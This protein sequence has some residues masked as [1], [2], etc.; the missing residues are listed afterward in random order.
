MKE[1]NNTH[2]PMN[3]VYL[4]GRISHLYGNERF[5]SLT[6]PYNEIVTRRVRENGQSRF[7][8]SVE[9]YFPEALFNASTKTKGIIQSFREGDHVLIKGYLGAYSYQTGGGF[10]E[11][12]AIYIDE[13]EHDATRME[14]MLGLGGFNGRYADAANEI[15]LEAKIAGIS[16]RREDIYEI[17]LETRKDG[18]TYAVTGMY[19]RAPQGLDQRIHLGDTV[20]VIGAMESARSEYRG[21]VY[22]TQTFVIQELVT[23]KEFVDRYNAAAETAQTGAADNAETARAAAEVEE[24]AAG[25]EPVE[26]PELDEPEELAGAAEAHAEE[27]EEPEAGT[28]PADN[29]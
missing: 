24:P 17:R 11:R 2:E 25:A 8:Q 9:T 10:A 15:R 26:I 12:T 20:Y 23:Q 22:F 4:R 14:Q 16:K 5:G 13:I 28:E 18:R 19:F 3:E 21:K 1:Q 7:E 27:A 6:V 29:E